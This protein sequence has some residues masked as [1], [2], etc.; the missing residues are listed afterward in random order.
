MVIITKTVNISWEGLNRHQCVV[1]KGI[2]M[3]WLTVVNNLVINVQNVV[4]KA[5]GTLDMI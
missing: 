5:N 1:A 2:L 3:S 4:S